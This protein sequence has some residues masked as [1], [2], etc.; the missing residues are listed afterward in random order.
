M[1]DVKNF[2]ADIWQEGIALT[3]EFATSIR[4]SLKKY[5]PKHMEKIFEVAEQMRVAQ[6]YTA[7]KE[8]FD[9]FL[10]EKALSLGAYGI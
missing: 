7:N 4:E 3:D 1:S 6:Q 5:F 9:D 8:K 10:K 2:V